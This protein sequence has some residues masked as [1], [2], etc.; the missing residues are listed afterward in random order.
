[1]SRR[2][3]PL[4][5]NQVEQ[6]QMERRIQ[7][8][9]ARIKI[10]PGV[11]PTALDEHMMFQHGF[12]RAYGDNTS[13]GVSESYYRVLGEEPL[14]IDGRTFKFGDYV[15]FKN[16]R[17]KVH[18]PGGVYPDNESIQVTRI[19][20]TTISFPD[21]RNPETQLDESGKETPD[22]SDTQ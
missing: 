11:L 10:T 7:E 22:C 2:K 6:P 9:F 8:S 13:E 19:V 4:C 18:V 5:Q 3:C 16:G 21:E 15:E 17:L 12:A 20:K 1:M 14:E